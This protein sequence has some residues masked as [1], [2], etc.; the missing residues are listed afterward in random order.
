MYVHTHFFSTV[1]F[2][3]DIRQA[4]TIP[5]LSE[6]CA[7]PMSPL[8]TRGQMAT[9]TRPAECRPRLWDLTL[10]ST[11]FP[12]DVK[13]MFFCI[14]NFRKRQFDFIKSNHKSTSLLPKVLLVFNPCKKKLNQIINN[15]IMI[16][17]I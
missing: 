12:V 16:L 5:H 9:R 2:R 8:S 3:G 11:L 13:C 15:I 10:L 1:I 17:R 4:I 6:V 7:I 14:Q